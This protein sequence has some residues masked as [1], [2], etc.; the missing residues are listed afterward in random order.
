MT[1]SKS[2]LSSIP[3]C[4]ATVSIGT[5]DT[6]LDQKLSAI[7]EAGFQGIELGFPDLLSFASKNYNK[8]VDPQ[9]YDTLCDAGRKVAIMVEDAG[10][11][12]VMLQPFSNF[13]G[14]EEGSEG[15]ED[16]FRRAR[17]WIRIM[18]AVGTDMLQVVLTPTHPHSHFPKKNKTTHTHTHTLKLQKQQVG[19]TDSPHALPS[20]DALASDLRALCDLLSPHKFRLA[21]ENWCWATH[22]PD[23]T[24][25]WTTVQ[26]VDRPNIGLCLDTFQTAGGEWADPT[27]ASGLIERPESGGQD[28]GLGERFRGSLRALAEMVPQEKIF[29]LQV[30]DAYRPREPLD[31]GADEQGLRPRARWSSCL[32]PVPFAGGYLP[33]VE[34]AKAVL[35]TGFRGWFSMEVFDGGPEGGDHEWKDLKGYATK[36]MKAHERLLQ[37]AADS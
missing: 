13:E 16:A 4:Y 5:P 26:K 30:S 28:E 20:L 3:T 21:Y 32:R 6:P 12:I 22:A 19:S 1:I 2:S 7:A 27:T 25:I 36:A 11:P 23:W 33:V 9:D 10:L 24:D 15:R 31:A 29:I 8:Q 18:Q 14:W 37:Q 34:V 35:G 17:G